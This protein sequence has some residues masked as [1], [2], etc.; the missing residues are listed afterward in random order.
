MTGPGAGA[1]ESAGAGAGEAARELFLDERDAYGCAE[2]AFVVLKEALGLRDAAA[3]AAAMAPNG[4]IAYSG[5]TSGAVTG[6]ALVAS[7]LGER[8]SPDH[9]AAKRAA[10]LV[11]ADLLAA[12]EGGSGP[13]P[14]AS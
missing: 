2:T 6:A 9:R 4:G 14:A 5:G 7:M 1:G 13:R 3:S 8:R 10:R 12:F 11:T